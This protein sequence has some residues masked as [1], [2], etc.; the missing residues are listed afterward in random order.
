MKPTSGYRSSLN[1]ACEPAAAGRARAHAR[2]LLPAWQVPED[3]VGD[4]VTVI[5]ELVT[6]AV[7]HASTTAGADTARVRTCALH[8]RLAHHQLVISV[9]DTDPRP[10]ARRVAAK[11]DES[12]RGLELV[13]LLC[14]DQW[15]FARVPGT[16]GK[17][18]WARLKLPSPCP[19]N[20]RA[21]RRTPVTG[22]S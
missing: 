14:Q 3:V 8:L 15:G 21:P 6:N 13:A 12:G 19:G 10:P 1:L 11:W 4:A 17:T 9:S 20:R 2:E 7:R 16:P 18:V 5:S 22:R